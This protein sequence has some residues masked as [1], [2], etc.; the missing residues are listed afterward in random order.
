MKLLRFKGAEA[1]FVCLLVWISSA[2]SSPAQTQWQPRASATFTKRP[3]WN[4]PTLGRL[5]RRP[6]REDSAAGF[7]AKKT[8]LAI[9]TLAV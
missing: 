4:L 6:R 5:P 8:Q 3:F 2:R 7:Y 1:L 9:A